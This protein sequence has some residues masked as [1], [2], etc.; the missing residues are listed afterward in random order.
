[1][2]TKMGEMVSPSWPYSC[3][4]LNQGTSMRFPE[5][6]SVVTLYTQHLFSLLNVLLDFHRI[7]ILSILG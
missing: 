6:S 3:L 7:L 1:M 5:A 2:E 4:G